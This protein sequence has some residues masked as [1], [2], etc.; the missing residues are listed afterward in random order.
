[1]AKKM[2]L[3]TLKSLIVEKRKLY[4]FKVL[5]EELAVIEKKAKKFARGN[6]SAWVR[7][8]SM[9]HVPKEMELKNDE[10]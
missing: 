4:N 7:Y 8:A 1:M 5:D 6:I 3:Q 10:S 9:N 2:S